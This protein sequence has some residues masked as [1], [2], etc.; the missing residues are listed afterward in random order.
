MHKWIDTVNVRCFKSILFMHG[1]PTPMYKM[2]LLLNNAKQLF[3]RSTLN[4]GKH[5]FGLARPSLSQ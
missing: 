1:A 4:F 5:Y 2:L 3:Q